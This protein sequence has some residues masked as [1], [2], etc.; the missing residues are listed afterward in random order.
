[1][2]NLPILLVFRTSYKIK[3]ICQKFIPDAVISTTLVIAE[4]LRPSNWIIIINIMNVF[5]FKKHQR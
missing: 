2:Q 1:M 5:S 4:L 3:N